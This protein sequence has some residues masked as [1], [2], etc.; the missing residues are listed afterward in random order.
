MSNDQGNMDILEY[1]DGEIMSWNFMISLELDF[2]AII[3][4][5]LAL[6]NDDGTRQ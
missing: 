1:F 6:N 2:T 3:K 5:W 4:T